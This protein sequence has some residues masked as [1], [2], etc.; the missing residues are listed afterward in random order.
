MFSFPQ[1]AE[2]KQIIDAYL[3][4]LEKVTV[5]RIIVFAVFYQLTLKPDGRHNFKIR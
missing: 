3:R 1:A 5:S 4:Q 2:A